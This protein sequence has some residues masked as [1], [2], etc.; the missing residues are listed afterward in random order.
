MSA[1]AEPVEE[2]AGFLEL[3]GPGTLREIA[4]D[5]YEIGLESSDRLL[6]G[7]DEILIVSAEMQI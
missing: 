2:L 6:D 5:H 1:L 3:L 7:L 4:A